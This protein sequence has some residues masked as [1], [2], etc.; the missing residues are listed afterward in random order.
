M[1]LVVVTGTGT[2]IGKT[3]VTAAS[4]RTLLDR[5]IGVTAH[6]PVQSFEPDATG[7][8]DA[9]VLGAATGESPF[10]VC[11]EHRWIPRAMAPPMAA[12]AL[13][14]APF[15]IA[16]LVREIGD[17]PAA[18]VVLVEGAGGA[19]SPL[20]D[21]GDT[22]D[23][24]RALQPELVVLVA[25]AGLGTINLVRLT[26]RALAPARVAVHLNRF[27]PDDA[28]HRANRDWLATREGLD[29]VTDIEAL[30][31]RIAALLATG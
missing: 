29:I 19:R 1:T 3:W 16:D 13:G 4:A 8:T 12:D 9:D 21:D 23:L 14:L 20:A 17:P 10:A 30:V 24:V 7:P 28:L 22:V 2:E 18:T 11:P 25:D 15:T 5:G 26:V 31:D 6:K 27:D